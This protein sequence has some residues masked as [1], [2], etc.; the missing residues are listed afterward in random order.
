MSVNN[1]KRK[2]L[3]YLFLFCLERILQTDIFRTFRS[4]GKQVERKMF[5]CLLSVEVKFIQNENLLKDCFEIRKNHNLYKTKTNLR[6]RN[7]F[8][9]VYLFYMRVML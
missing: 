6:I 9:N 4:I 1:W 3:F 8:S 7:Q 5:F 2:V